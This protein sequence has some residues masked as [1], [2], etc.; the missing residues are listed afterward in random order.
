VSATSSRRSKTPKKSKTKSRGSSKS[1]VKNRTKSNEKSSAERLIREAIRS[2]ASKGSVSKST[3]L[4]ERAHYGTTIFLASC[5]LSMRMGRFTA[6][7]FQDLI[8]KGYILALAYG[9]IHGAKELYTRLHSSCVTSETLRGCDCDCS[10][11]LEGALKRIAE[12]KAGILFYLIQ[13]GRGVGYVAKARDRMLVQASLDELSTFEAYAELGLKK[14]YRNYEGIAS[15]VHLL[16]VKAPFVVLTNNPDK[17]SALKNLGVKVKGTESIEF[18]AG[19]YNLAYLK[20][21]AQ[22]GHALKRPALA[23]LRRA[24]PPEKVIPFN[25]Y[26][27]KEGARFIYC[28][29]Y[30]LP[31]KPV[32]GEAIISREQFEE[33]FAHNDLEQYQKG[34]KALISAVSELDRERVLVQMERKNFSRYKNDPTHA[35]VVALVTTP[36]WFRVHVYY[37]VVSGQDFVVLTHGESKKA[38]A[39]ANG[40][41]ESAPLVRVHSE[42][43]FDRFPMTDVENRDKLKQSAKMIVR[44]GTGLIVL[45]YNDG[46]GAGFGAHATDRMFRER[47]VTKSTDETYAQLGVPYDSRDYEA[48]MLLVAHHVRTKRIQMIMNNPHSLVLKQEYAMALH[49]QGLQIER[50]IFLEEEFR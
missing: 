37:D 12:R 34:P 19:P 23:Q 42:S 11:Q 26:A 10:K 35:E 21:K 9:D 17:V 44:N 4:M 6:Y 27:L 38:T 48:T 43:I 24:I 13:E 45:L 29:S 8:H 5:D 22:S 1:V 32:D 16:G 25:P 3:P 36:Y 39:K 7:V 46:R 15:I 50:W 20:S 47:R 28:A 14:D 41:A 2:V 49:R 40:K 30:F 31:M 33:V 18:D